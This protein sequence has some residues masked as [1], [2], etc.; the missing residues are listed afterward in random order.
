LT[1]TLRCLWCDRHCCLCGKAA[2][3][4]IEV[5]HIDP[6]RNDLDNAIPLCFDCHSKIGHYNDKHPRGK[7]YSSDELKTRREQVY[8]Q[9]TRYLVPA[10]I[11]VIHQRAFRPDQVNRELPDVGFHMSNTGTTYAVKAH[12]V[13]TLAQ[14][15]DI[16]GSPGEGHYDGKYLWN[17]NPQS[18]VNGH[19]KLPEGMSL[20]SEPLRARVD[21]T[22]IDYYGRRHTLL[23]VGFVHRL[24]EGDE[25]Y[26]E[27]SEEAFLIQPKN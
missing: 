18:G 1:R 3:V 10:V 19:F 5:A 14:G 27:P 25:W 2:G 23:P 12:V 8:E 7:K 24:G 6:K 15:L 13:V 4:G 20:H 22:L 17:L 21:V 16:F 9:H 26:F 11:Y